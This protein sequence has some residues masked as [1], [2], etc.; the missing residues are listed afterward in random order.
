[1]NLIEQTK[2]VIAK[3]KFNMFFGTIN[4]QIITFKLKQ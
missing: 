4:I 3:R 2:L 1:M